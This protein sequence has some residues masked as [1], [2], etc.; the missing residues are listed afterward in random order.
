M[1]LLQVLKEWGPLVISFGQLLL[2]L[3]SPAQ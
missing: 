2:M 3:R 1:L